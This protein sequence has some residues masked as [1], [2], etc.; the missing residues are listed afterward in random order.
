MTVSTIPSPDCIRRLRT[1]QG[2][3]KAE[4]ARR[5]D[6]TWK[7]YHAIETGGDSLVSTLRRIAD[8][9]GVGIAELL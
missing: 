7:S 1:D 4:V 9:L 8:A 6:L 2:L 3:S 5:A